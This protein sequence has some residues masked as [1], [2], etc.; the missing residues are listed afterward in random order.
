LAFA[1]TKRLNRRDISSSTIP[2]PVSCTE[3]IK[4]ISSSSCPGGGAWAFL[5]SEGYHCTSAAEDGGTCVAVSLM[6][7]SRRTESFVNFMALVIKL[8]KTCS[9]VQQILL[10]IHDKLG[11]TC[12]SRK[13]SQYTQSAARCACIGSTTKLDLISNDCNSALNICNVN[14][15][16]STGCI[17][18]GLISNM[19]ES[20]FDTVNM[21]SII[22]EIVSNV[23][24]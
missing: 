18:T 7:I 13:G 24:A 4:Y 20:S 6:L 3:N 15:T 17:S 22:L 9:H 10:V 11:I 16:V 1:C 23:L 12:E 14:L 2:L 5:W 21:S 19:A 8:T